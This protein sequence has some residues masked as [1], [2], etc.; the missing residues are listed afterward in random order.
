MIRRDTDVVSEILGLVP[1]WLGGETGPWDEAFFVGFE[2]SDQ[3]LTMLARVIGR[4]TKGSCLTHP[5]SY[6]RCRIAVCPSLSPTC[7][8]LTGRKSMST[9][10]TR[11]N[12]I[13]GAP[14]EVGISI[15]G[16]SM[17]GLLETAGELEF[18][19]VHREMV[20]T[21]A[22]LASGILPVSSF[23]GVLDTVTSLILPMSAPTNVS[24]EE[25]R[26]RNAGW[27]SLLSLL[28][29]MLRV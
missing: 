2:D 16:T 25:C 15:V 27:I 12:E 6:T 22:T 10:Y 17:V 9:R 23:G 5:S 18:V 1:Y 20:S 13:G 19:D 8:G 21:V 3:C 24:V 11:A 14:G 4:V 26:P 29:L 28:L 7:S